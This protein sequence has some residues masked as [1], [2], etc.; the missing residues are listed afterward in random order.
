MS[1]SHFAGDGFT[2][3]LA[4]RA[5]YAKGIKYFLASFWRA[6]YFGGLWPAISHHV[7][8]NFFALL[9]VACIVLWQD[10]RSKSL[11]FAAGALAGLTTAFL[12]PKG[13]LLFCALLVWLWIQHRRKA[14]SLSSLGELA[15]GYLSVIGLILLYFWSK[16]AL[17]SLIYVNL[18]WPSQHYQAVNTLPYAHGILSNYWDHWVIAGSGFRWTI[19]MAAVLIIPHPAYRSAPCTSTGS[20]SP[21]QM[22]PGEAGDP[23]LLAV[24]RRNLAGR[25]SPK[26]D[27][28]SCVWLA[29]A[30]CSMHL[31]PRRISRKDRHPSAPGALNKRCLS[32]ERLTFFVRYWRRIP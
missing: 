30:D 28:T 4:C 11:L 10:R 23:A 20:R 27:D 5:G 31:L 17:G 12:Q 16:G 1:L 15:G 8:S 3:V 13:V 25:A 19:L 9:A 7:D 32:R 24:R 29:A 26:G 22:E 2:D 14:A 21:L 18:V 6:T